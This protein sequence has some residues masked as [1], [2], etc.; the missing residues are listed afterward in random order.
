MS[1][2]KE[3]SINLN[4]N[5]YN[6]Y[7]EWHLIWSKGMVIGDF[8]NICIIMSYIGFN[9]KEIDLA[10]L[11]MNNNFTDKAVFDKN[12]KFL[13]TEDSDINYEYGAYSI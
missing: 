2:K 10:I 13:F 7:N 9:F 8:S 11:E 1:N 6:F 3:T 4:Y 12:K 5:L